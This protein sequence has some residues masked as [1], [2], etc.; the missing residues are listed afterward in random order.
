MATAHLE[1]D[2]EALV[3]S[4][5]PNVVRMHNGGG[6]PQVGSRLSLNALARC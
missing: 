4:L 5:R 2:T 1:Y 6:G 3:L